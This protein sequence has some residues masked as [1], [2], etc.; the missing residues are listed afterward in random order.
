MVRAAVLVGYG[1][2]CDYETSYALKLAGAEVEQ[3]H[4]S[5]LGEAGLERFEILAI[6]GGFSFGDDIAAGKML[7]NKLKAAAGSSIEQFVSDG[8]LAI[9]ICNGFQALAKYALLPEMGEQKFTLT[10]NDSGRFEDRWV[11]LKAEGNSIWTRGISSLYLPVRHGEG[12]FV[13]PK[14]ELRHIEREGLV[15]LRYA[16]AEGGKPSYPDNPNGSMNDIAGITDRSGRV[17]GLMP[18][19]EASLYPTNHPRWTRG[20]RDVLGIEL[21]K[22]AV[23]F[24][25]EELV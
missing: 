5:G 7:A 22:N 18:H 24:A 11:H 10:F 1:I 17:L 23:K 25:E 15:A 19:P 9:G 14:E 2:N 21:F 4:I 20:E 12:K 8:K 13:A 3:V 16:S 6:P